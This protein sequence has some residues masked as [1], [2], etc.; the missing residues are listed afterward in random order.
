MGA[1]PCILAWI[2]CDG[3]TRW[4]HLSSEHS[5]P[6]DRQYGHEPFSSGQTEAPVFPKH[7]VQDSSG[8]FWSTLPRWRGAQG[9]LARPQGNGCSCETTE[10]ALWLWGLFWRDPPAQWLPLF[11]Y[12]PQKQISLL[13]SAVTHWA[14]THMHAERLFVLIIH[15]QS[16][17]LNS[18]LAS[19]ALA[20]LWSHNEFP[21]IQSLRLIS[22]SSFH[23]S[24]S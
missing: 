18:L 21:M 9:P 19:A 24:D 3:I 13:Q 16:L 5:G 23:S 11:I 22:R 4:C 2:C 17:N 14:H 8:S 10:R 15:K 1:K 7:G 12:T 6:A 20:S